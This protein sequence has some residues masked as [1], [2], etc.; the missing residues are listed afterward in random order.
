[1]GGVYNVFA[2]L[3]SLVE[4]GAEDVEVRI[5]GDLVEEAPGNGAAVERVENDVSILVVLGRELALDLVDD[6]LVDV[7][8]WRP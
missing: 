2:V 7:G 6:G 5:I 8:D 4:R 3:G 1:V